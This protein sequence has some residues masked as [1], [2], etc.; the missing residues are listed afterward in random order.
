MSWVKGRKVKECPVASRPGEGCVG[1]QG[2]DLLVLAP[3]WL[4]GLLRTGEWLARP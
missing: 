1:A 3:R 2:A 4:T